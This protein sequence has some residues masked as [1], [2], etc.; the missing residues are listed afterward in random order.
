MKKV[1]NSVK[2]R[3]MKRRDSDWSMKEWGEENEEV[4]KDM[5]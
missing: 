3:W 1:V 5:S 4:I 2:K